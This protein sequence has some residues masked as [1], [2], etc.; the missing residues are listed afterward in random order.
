MPYN[1]QHPLPAK[2]V[3]PPIPTNSQKVGKTEI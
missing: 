3:I 1:K 2:A